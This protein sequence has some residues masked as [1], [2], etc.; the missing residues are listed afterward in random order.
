MVMRDV[1]WKSPLKTST[2]I[3]RTEKRRIVVRDVLSGPRFRLSED[4]EKTVYDFGNLHMILIP[5]NVCALDA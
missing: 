1:V 5:A 4:N 2:N 3:L